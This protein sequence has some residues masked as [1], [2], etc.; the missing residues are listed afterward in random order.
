[1][2]GNTIR[3]FNRDIEFMGEVDDFTSLYFIRSWN[4]YGT[5]E[6]EMDREVH[7]MVAENYIMINNDSKLSGVIKTVNVKESINGKKVLIKGFSLSYLLSN[8]ITEPPSGQGYDSFNYTVDGIMHFLVDHN[9]IM[10]TNV[11]RK[12]P[13]LVRKDYLGAGQVIK[14]QTRYKNLLD[15]LT[16]LSTM[17][18]LGFG[19]ELN[20]NTKQLEFR[21]Y[22]GK[23][24]TT[25]QTA[26]PPKIFS[27]EYDNVY[28]SEF[29]YNTEESKNTA[30]VGGQGEEENRVVQI[31][32][33]ANIGL[34]R[35]E[36]F[37]DA[38]DIKETDNLEDR[39]NEKLSKYQ[40]VIEYECEVDTSDYLKTWDLGDLVTVKV[41]DNITLEKQIT[42]IRLIFEKSNRIEVSFGEPL[43]SLKEKIQRELDKPIQENGKIYYNC[44]QPVTYAVGTQWLEVVE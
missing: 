37:V 13:N 42:E 41:N 32:N 11:N 30:I 4:S 16:N 17:S 20:V 38:R 7:G 9:C 43:T 15:E 2:D 21:V 12:M 33:N 35:K 19:I 44:P 29:T 28:D 31:V 24:L 40:D 39:A 10:P 34:D 18:Y 23:D 6:I 5:F 25:E 14:F 36:L 1:M 8:R 27:K 3:I 22:Q 26:N